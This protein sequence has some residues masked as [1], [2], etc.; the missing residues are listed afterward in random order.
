MHGNAFK[1]KL[2]PDEQQVFDNG[3]IVV[4]GNTKIGH[5]TFTAFHPEPFVNELFKKHQVLDHIEGEISNGKPQ[6]DI[7]IVKVVK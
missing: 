4:K 2:T 3:Q 1:T 5:R 7:W 6:Q